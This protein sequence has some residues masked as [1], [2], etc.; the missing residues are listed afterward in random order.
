MGLYRP[1]GRFMIRNSEP[2]LH[3]AVKLRLLTGFTH[4]SPTW[5]HKCHCDDLPW[6]SSLTYAQNE[7]LSLAT[8]HGHRRSKIRVA[9]LSQFLRNIAGCFVSEWLSRSLKLL[10]LAPWCYWIIRS[11]EPRDTRRCA[12]SSLSFLGPQSAAWRSFPPTKGTKRFYSCDSGSRAPAT[13]VSNGSVRTTRTAVSVDQCSAGFIKSQKTVLEA[14]VT[15]KQVSSSSQTIKQSAA[16]Y[17]SHILHKNKDGKDI[18]IHYCKTL[19]D[20]EKIAHHFLSDTVI[21][22]DLEWKS[23]ASATDSIQNNVSLIQLANHDRIALFQISLFSP[24]STLKDLVSPTLKHILENPA[25]TKTGVAIKADCTR[26]RK[27]L[28]IH[29]RSIFELSHLHK[30]VKYCHTS[31]GLINKRPVSL[32]EQVKEHFGL[33]MVKDDDVRCGNWAVPLSSRQIHYAAADAYAG[34][35]LFRTM[36]AKRRALVPVPPLPAHAELNLPIRLIA[37]A[38]LDS[39]EKSDDELVD[40]PRKT[41]CSQSI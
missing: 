40:S 8:T 33:P 12:L 32:T 5:E 17:W 30:L 10:H 35:Q 9:S 34:Y 29:A 7:Q 23:Q 27:Y 26:L 41:K 18:T 2:P 19:E 25:I 15:S 16:K 11:L 1:L 3:S 4:Q 36:D 14:S 6:R 20:T 28:G 24:G 31:P 38:G 22:L 21:G 37:S 13:S 39:V